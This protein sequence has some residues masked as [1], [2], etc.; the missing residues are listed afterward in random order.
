MSMTAAVSAGP[1]AII[2]VA[3]VVSIQA[4]IVATEGQ[5]NLDSYRRIQE[6]ASENISSAYDLAS[7][8]VSDAERIEVSMAMIDLITDGNW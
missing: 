4:G 7:G 1:A 3:I 6:M 2:A 5:E 8:G